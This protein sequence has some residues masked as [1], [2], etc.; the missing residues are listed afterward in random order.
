MTQI[1]QKQTTPDPRLT[2]PP[3]APEAPGH[4]PDERRA[5][6]E[7]GFEG[8]T[9][10]LKPAAELSPADPPAAAETPTTEDPE[11]A[12]RARVEAARRQ[13][14]QT[15]SSLIGGPLYDL[16]HEHLGAD[17]ML[18][19]AQ[20]GMPA[21][22]QQGA[23]LLG[24]LGRNADEA[25]VISAFSAEVLKWS[26]EQG[27]K[28]LQ[29]EKGQAFLTRVNHWVEE[30]P[31]LVATTLVAAA[32]GA[33]AAV[34]FSN[35]DPPNFAQTFNLGHGWSIN[36]ALDL[37]P[38]QEW[39]V[40]SA[41]AGVRYQVEGGLAAVNMKYDEKTG[42]V[43]DAS[44]EI[45]TAGGTKLTGQ[46]TTNIP[47]EGGA[48]GEFT[49]GVAGESGSATV[50]VDT[51]G[52]Q[53]YAGDITF[54]GPDG[55]T[56][57]VKG[58]VTVDAEGKATIQ[59]GTEAT[60]EIKG[61]T[62]TESMNLNVDADGRVTTERGQSVGVV[63]DLGRFTAGTT[64]T[65]NAE[66]NTEVKSNMGLTGENYALNGT[67][68]VND[69]GTSLVD[70]SGNRQLG[71]LNLGLGF[72]HGRDGAG[73]TTNSAVKA[74]MAVGN[75]QNYFNASGSYNFV[76][77]QATLLT[78]SLFTLDPVTLG[79]NTNLLRPEWVRRGGGRQSGG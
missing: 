7:A 63:T 15:L 56:H 73:Q 35:L 52:N 38:I 23:G 20:Q 28:W 27:T 60:A 76:D 13:Y 58:T 74:S 71:L 31:A 46:V 39:V 41:E 12:E 44:G 21:L 62:V 34:Y 78:K 19:Y 30:H 10:Q 55:R 75:E 4:T 2:F 69:D 9:A 67:L 70:L 66:G 64:Q 50:T 51:K 5:A 45:K 49:L 42:F 40:R 33:G 14:E 6:A 8:A 25:K 59:T 57:T 3:A 53:R 72:T 22:A 68:R 11:A 48:S 16:I 17:D 29:S 24:Q 54:A 79:L 61:G 26:G 36:G 37:G 77:H 1:H 47:K 65:T 18:A 32:L 43:V